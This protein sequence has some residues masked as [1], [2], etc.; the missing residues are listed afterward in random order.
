MVRVPLALGPWP[1]GIP[2][3]IVALVEYILVLASIVN[4]LS[5]C[6][7]ISHHAVLSWGCTRTWPTIVW[8]LVPLFIN[9]IASI[10]YHLTLDRKRARNMHADSRHDMLPPE[11][12]YSFFTRPDSKTGTTTTVSPPTPPPKHP[13][14]PPLITSPSFFHRF[15]FW[16]KRELSPSASHPPALRANLSA[17]LPHLSPRLII[18]ILL[19]CF[20]G[21]LSCFHLLY[22]TVTFSGLL[23]IDT[24]DAIGQIAMRLLASALVCRFVGLVEVAGMR[25]GILAARNR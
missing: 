10:G 3:T 23:F 19:H 9:L 17:T 15:L 13:I 21:F 11:R 4:T 2:S 20:A 18:G 16:I 22:G 12:T 14:H 8:A 24:L 25:G 1:R 6:I 5:L 7:Q